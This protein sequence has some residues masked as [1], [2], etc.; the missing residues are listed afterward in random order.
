MPVKRV[1][2][3]LQPP[4]GGGWD[5][6]DSVHYLSVSDASKRQTESASLSFGAAAAAFPLFL[7]VPVQQGGGALSLSSTQEVLP[8]VFFI[9]VGQRGGSPLCL[10]T[11]VLIQPPRTG[12][13]RVHL[14]HL[15]VYPGSAT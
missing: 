8:C 12:G 11:Q 9:L 5:S 14:T 4:A 13:G 6:L 3:P 10:L 1:L 2:R 15:P 7:P